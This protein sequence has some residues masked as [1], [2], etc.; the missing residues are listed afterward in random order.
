MIST[1][2]A[3]FILWIFFQEF[4]WKFLLEFICEFLQR[5]VGGYSKSSWGI[6]L[7]GFWEIRQWNISSIQFLRKFSKETWGNS[8]YRISPGMPSGFLTEIPSRNFSE[9]IWAIFLVGFLKGFIGNFYHWLLQ[10][11]IH[12]FHGQIIPTIRAFQGILEGFFANIIQSFFLGTP[13]EFYL[14]FIQKFPMEYFEILVGEY[15]QE[16]H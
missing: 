7:G 11:F 12:G 4:Y 2:T 5:F 10:E 1:E 14:K 9:I 6:L 15:I 16:F 13:A 8:L 3:S